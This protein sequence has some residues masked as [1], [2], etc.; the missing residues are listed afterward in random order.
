MPKHALL[1]ASSSHRWLH[2]PP[3][4]KLCA[5]EDNKPSPYAQEGTDAHSLCQFKLEQALGMKT[6]DPIENLEFYDGEMESYAEEYVAF[7]IEQF[8]EARHYCSDP[9]ILIE[10]HL[11]F[12]KY[13]E[14]GFG[15]G[16][17]VIVADNVLQ[18]ID[19]KY[20]LGILVSADENPQMMCYALGAIEIFDGI[21]DIDT[22]KMTIFQPR[23][24]NVSTCTLSKDTLLRWGNEVLSPIAKLAYTGEGEFKAGDHCQFCKVKATCRKRAEYNLELAK[25]DFAIP[26]NLDNTEI[27]VILTKVDN[28]VAWIND[29]K[30]YALEQA[31]NG[32]KYDGFKI[33]EGRSTRKYTNEQTVAETV[34]L[35]GFNP[36]EHKLL[37][38][39]AMTSVLGKKKFEEILGSLVIKAPGKPTLV[40]EN[41]KRPEFNTAQ[42]DFNKE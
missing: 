29:I 13:V 30:D 35:A 28:L 12:S 7:V 19:Y 41:D 34:T 1:S 38:V 20:G 2:C 21:Y 6:N 36:F 9:V 24:D 15:T 27:S 17:C 10:Q 32:T 23:R 18:I 31:L 42:I 14:S 33:V 39:T 3:S 26:P 4:A 16:D 11:D 25:Y 37:G 5:E 8:E 40:P 22:V